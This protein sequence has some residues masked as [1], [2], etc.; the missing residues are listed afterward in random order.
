MKYAFTVTFE[1]PDP[2]TASFVADDIGKHIVNWSLC[3]SIQGIEYGPIKPKKDIA[4]DK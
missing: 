4:N 3:Q 2:V 1:A